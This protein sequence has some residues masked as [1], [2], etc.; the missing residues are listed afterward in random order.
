MDFADACLVAMTEEFSDPMLY[1][2]DDNFRF[3][4]RHR[5]D[6]IPFMSPKVK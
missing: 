3:Y 6:V 5:R 1:T 2:L 4:R